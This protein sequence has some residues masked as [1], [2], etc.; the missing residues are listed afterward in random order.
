ME[1][2]LGGIGFFPSGNIGDRHAFF[3]SIH[4]SAP[5]IAGNDPANPISQILPLAMMLD[6][7]DE[8]VAG[9]LVRRA[10]WVALERKRLRVAAGGLFDGGI[11]AAAQTVAQVVSELD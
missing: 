10:V 2:F 7:L 1:N 8:T 11:K 3:E 9:D 5:D 6:H 4:G